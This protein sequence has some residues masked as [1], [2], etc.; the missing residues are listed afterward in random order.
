MAYLNPLVLDNG[1]S[2]LSGAT[3]LHICSAEPTTFAGIAAVSLGSKA[4][5]TVGAPANRSGGGRQV[6]VSAF[7]DGSITA[8]GTATHYALASGTQ[9]LAANSLVEPQAVTNGNPFQLSSFT[10]GIP[11]V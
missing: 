2:V 10:I 1:L 4:N 9:L 8:N 7:T 6:T 11:G 5:P 3:V